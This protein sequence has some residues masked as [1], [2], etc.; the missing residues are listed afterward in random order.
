MKR[1]LISLAAAFVFALVAVLL[2]PTSASAECL[3]MPSYI[4]AYPDAYVYLWVYYQ[5]PQSLATAIQSGNAFNWIVGHV[6][7]S[8][9]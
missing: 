1:R 8:T 6:C 5:D 7:A 9:F 4:W 2:T 3:N